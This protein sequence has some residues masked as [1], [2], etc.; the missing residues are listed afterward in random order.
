M[1][2]NSLAG[3]WQS[4]VIHQVEIVN[5]TSMEL[6]YDVEYNSNDHGCVRLV[7]KETADTPAIVEDRKGQT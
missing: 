5:N 4:T 6:E 1:G 3:F 2:L 7:I